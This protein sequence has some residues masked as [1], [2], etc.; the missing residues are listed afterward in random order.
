[1]TKLAINLAFGVEVLFFKYEIVCGYLPLKM[2][3][4]ILFILILEVEH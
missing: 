2:Y 1:M 3:W 4:A